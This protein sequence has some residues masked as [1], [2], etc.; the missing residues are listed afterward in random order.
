MCF[1]MNASHTAV[2]G[3]PRDFQRLSGG[4]SSKPCEMENRTENVIFQSG[5]LSA[6][7]SRC[8][9][10]KRLPQ[11]AGEA[12]SCYQ[13]KTSYFARAWTNAEREIMP[14]PGS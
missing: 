6:A 11:C 3:L 4:S 12:D 9:K 7:G 8:T 1:V 2:A 13:D 5:V 10:A 14:A